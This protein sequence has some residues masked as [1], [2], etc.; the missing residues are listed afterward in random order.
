M[1]WSKTSP[2]DHRWLISK[3]SSVNRWLKSKLWW[4]NIFPVVSQMEQQGPAYL[5][6]GQFAPHALGRRDRPDA[7]QNARHQAYDM[8]MQS[9]RE[10]HNK[11]RRPTREWPNMH[12]SM[13]TIVSWWLLVVFTFSLW[14][15]PM[16][17]QNS[18]RSLLISSGGSQHNDP[19]RSNHFVILSVCAWGS[20][21]IQGWRRFCD[22]TVSND[23]S[24]A[25]K[26]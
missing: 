17:Y 13:R 8:R 5:T 7:V 22:I 11:V 15:S 25:Q 10:Q 14:G 21:G 23:G 1:A 9:S 20:A 2:C 24:C 4:W 6:T 12:D 18:G 26:V 19:R 16:F 3:L